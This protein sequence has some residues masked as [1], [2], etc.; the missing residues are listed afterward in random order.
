MKHDVLISQDLDSLSRYGTGRRFV[1][2]VNFTHLILDHWGVQRSPDTE[3]VPTH[4][5]HGSCLL[6]TL[7][8]IEQI[9][10]VS[11]CLI[12]EAGVVRVSPNGEF[13]LIVLNL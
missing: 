1:S 2:R 11:R 8:L 4:C 12:S 7:K 5:L 6:K 13:L 9:A 3:R 10:S